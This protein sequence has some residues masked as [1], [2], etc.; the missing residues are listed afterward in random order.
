MSRTDHQL[1]WRKSSRCDAGSCVE[2]AI[3]PAEVHVRNS[4][5]PET[6]LSFSRAEWSAFVSA[7][8]RGELTD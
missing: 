5:D 8:A 7:L 4:T 1:P 6:S 2:V 3:T